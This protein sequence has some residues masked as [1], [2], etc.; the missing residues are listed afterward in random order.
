ML[1]Q[2]EI[3]DGR[4]PLRT[5]NLEALRCPLSKRRFYCRKTPVL[6]SRYSYRRERRQVLQEAAAT[7]RS[8]YFGERQLR[9]ID[10]VRVAVAERERLSETHGSSGSSRRAV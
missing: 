1:R 3:C 9:W 7:R 4:I 10:F 8:D 5:S 6:L 2:A